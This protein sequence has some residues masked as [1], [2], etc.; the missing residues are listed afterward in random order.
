VQFDA[1]GVSLLDPERGEF[2]VIDLPARSIEG[3]PRRDTTMSLPGTLLER[4]ASA[5]APVLID[6]VAAA[7]VPPASREAFGSRG[8]RAAILVPLSSRGRVFGALTVAAFE[9]RAFDARDV[10]RLREL[11]GPL[12]SAIDPRRL[13]EAHRRRNDDR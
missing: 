4:V 11:A 3:G 5:G 2:E 13:A 8:Y 6:D 1:I 9:P 7:E 10:V 12:A